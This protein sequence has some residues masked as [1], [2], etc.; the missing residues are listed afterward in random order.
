MSLTMKRRSP[1]L[2]SPM[3]RAA[4]TSVAPFVVEASCSWS[5]RFCAVSCET[6]AVLV[7]GFTVAVGVGFGVVV[8]ASWFANLAQNSA[9]VIPVAAIALLQ[10]SYAAVTRAGSEVALRALWSLKQVVSSS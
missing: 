1:G 9:V 2:T 3:R 6:S 10:A 4:C 5:A 8:G 7:T